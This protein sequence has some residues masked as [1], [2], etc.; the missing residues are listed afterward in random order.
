MSRGGRVLLLV[1]GWVF[2][3]LAL[4][5]AAGYYFYTQRGPVE[6]AVVWGAVYTSDM[7]GVGLLLV[8]LTGILVLCVAAAFVFD[9]LCDTTARAAQGTDASLV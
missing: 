6:V 1:A 9:H 2:V 3:G 8:E 4:S 5:A 7:T